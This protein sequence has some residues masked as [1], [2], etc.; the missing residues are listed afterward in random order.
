MSSTYSTNLGTNLMATGDQSGTW[1][2][3]TNFNLGTLMEQAISSYVTQQFNNADVTLTLVNGSDAGGNTTPGTIYTAGT[4]AVPVSARNMYIE[5]Q[6]TSSGN[7]LIVPTN[8]K[9]YYVYNNISSGGGT[10]TVKTASGTGVA[11]PVGQRD[12]LVCN[13]TNVVQAANYFST[14]TS[15]SVAITGGTIDGTPVGST[16]ASTVR[17]TTIT[18]TTQFTGPGTGLTGTASGLSIGGNA[19]TVTNGVYTS[20]SYSNPS[21]ITSILGSI[22]SGAV[23]SATSASTATTATNLSGGSVAA[24]TITASGSTVLGSATGGSQ[25]AGTLNATGVFVNGVAVGTGSGSVTSVSG[26]GTVSGLTLTGTVTTSGSLTLGGTLSL[27]SGQVTTALGYTPPTPTGT[28]ASG[29]WGINIS[30]NAATVTNGLTTSNYNSY[31]PTLTGTGASGTWGISISGNAATASSASSASYATSAGS[32]SYATSAG[33]AT[34]ITAYTINQNLGTSN[35]PTFASLYSNGNIYDNSNTSY[36]VRPSITSYLYAVVGYGTSTFDGVSSLPWQIWDGIAINANGAGPATVMSFFSNGAPSSR[37]GWIG[38]TG[39]STSYNTSS[40]YRLKLN[41]QVLTNSGAVID[42]LIPRTW[43]WADGTPGIGMLA[44]EAQAAGLTQTVHGVK[45]GMVDIGNLLDK[46]NNVIASSVRQPP[47]LIDGQT[48]VKTG[49]APDYQ[50]MEYGS[51]EFMAYI[52]AELKSLRG[53]VATLE[54]K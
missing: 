22:V 30:G 7:N 1:G 24:T 31:A 23:A 39:S 48:W 32:A 26:T 47:K 37:A 18:A 29:T 17:G 53:R 54:A 3:T 52:I 2:N 49:Q 15:P 27:T 42:A 41:P 34:N 50:S 40:D 9:I 6:G 43:T 25:G 5:C 8:T 12:C 35:S 21:W 11:I 28:G 10:I 4:V 13:G 14:L 46:D 33:S 20:G 16:T 51:A 36:Y 38:V 44:H 45:D 19:A